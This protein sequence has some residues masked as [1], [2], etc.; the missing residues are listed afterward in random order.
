M[1]A[2][3]SVN[4]QDE[5][6]CGENSASGS[7]GLIA[8][9]G[10]KVDIT[11]DSEVTIKVASHDRGKVPYGYGGHEKAIGE[12]IDGSPHG[13]HALI[14]ARCFVLTQQRER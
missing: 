5:K 14:L 3:E 12:K 6:K 8:Y 13:E 2:V 4:Q 9:T 1:L 10:V 7:T 11:V